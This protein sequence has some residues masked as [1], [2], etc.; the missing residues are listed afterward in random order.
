MASPV[1]TATADKQSYA[2]GDT[3]IVSW[4]VVDADNATQEIIF[5]GHDGQGNVVE[6]R[7]IVNRQDPFV[8]DRVYW[9]ES[10]E[11]LTIDQAARRASGIVPNA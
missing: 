6:A 4:T 1:I 9:S 2:P 11:N 7:L 3:I 8:M 5:T 10:G